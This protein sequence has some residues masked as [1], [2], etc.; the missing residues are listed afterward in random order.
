[1]ILNINKIMKI[2]L[3]KASLLFS[4][5]SIFPLF[6]VYDKNEISFF[7]FI[8]FYIPIL[9]L[10]I[11]LI[12]FSKRSFISYLGFSFISS[13]FSFSF[14][15]AIK[16]AF[17][18]YFYYFLSAYLLVFIFDFFVMHRNGFYHHYK[19][20]FNSNIYNNE[21]LLDGQ[22]EFE[23]LKDYREGVIIPKVNY[24]YMFFLPVFILMRAFVFD[25]TAVDSFLGAIINVDFI[26]GVCFVYAFG[27]SMF[28]VQ[29]FL[30]KAYFSYN[31]KG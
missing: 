7:A 1:M 5:V 10:F 15:L 29:D 22:G 20:K 16:F 17:I 18:D 3:L 28:L 21:Y 8:E 12:L 13:F 24:I 9:M 2:K 31:Y 25:V 11:A 4:T 23:Q 14:L 6:Y 26:M 30:T 27:G 19:I